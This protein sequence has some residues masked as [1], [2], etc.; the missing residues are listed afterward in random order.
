M[1]PESASLLFRMQ[2][3]T[4]EE[5]TQFMEAF[6]S[7]APPIMTRQQLVATLATVLQT[8]CDTDD[9]ET[10]DWIANAAVE[11]VIGCEAAVALD[12][13]VGPEDGVN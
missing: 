8:Y 5:F 1:T 4:D 9:E 10:M 2:P 7:I 11:T 6:G 13:A 3:L 12:M